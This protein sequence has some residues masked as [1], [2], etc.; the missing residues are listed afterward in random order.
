[1]EK[2]LKTIRIEN[3]E[4]EIKKITRPD[5]SWVLKD[6]KDG[7]PFSPYCYSLNK[8]I[9]ISKVEDLHGGMPV[10]DILVATVEEGIKIWV[11]NKDKINP[12]R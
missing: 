10:L 3:D 1:M 8:N 7:Q 11:N 12:G 9:N 6:F 5:G 2:T 4:Y